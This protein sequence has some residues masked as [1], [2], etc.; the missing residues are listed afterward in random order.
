MLQQQIEFAYDPYCSVRIAF[1]TKNSGRYDLVFPIIRFAHLWYGMSLREPSEAA[2][3]RHNELYSVNYERIICSS[4]NITVL[5]P[6]QVF[7]ERVLLHFI[8]TMHS[9][10]VSGKEAK[11]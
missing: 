10:W 9:I 6:P 5:G 3:I 4:G 2:G 1:A 8:K 7:D 11:S